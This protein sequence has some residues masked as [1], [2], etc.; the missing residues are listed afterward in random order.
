MSSHSY[1][2]AGSAPEV[3]SPAHVGL[4]MSR[5]V[6]VLSSSTANPGEFQLW[7]IIGGAPPP[8]LALHQGHAPGASRFRSLLHV[9]SSAHEALKKKK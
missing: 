9:A 1:A 5:G 2:H 7:S 4:R 6:P 8:V 3:I